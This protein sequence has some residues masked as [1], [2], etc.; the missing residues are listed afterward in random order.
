MT[1]WLCQGCFQ[2]ATDNSF[3]IPT[4]TSIR[5]IV[6]EELEPISKALSN[7]KTQVKS[8]SDVVGE[9]QVEVLAAAS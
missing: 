1:K 5:Q 4:V 7:V 3:Y 8:Y 9:N 2:L 6:K